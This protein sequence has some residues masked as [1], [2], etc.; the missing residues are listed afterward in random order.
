[1]NGTQFAD[2]SHS[3]LS[4]ARDTVNQ[5]ITRGERN[6]YVLQFLQ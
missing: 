3:L 1:M 5:I 6:Y 4:A 2:R